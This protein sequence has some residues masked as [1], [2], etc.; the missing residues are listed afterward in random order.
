MARDLTPEDYAQSASQLQSVIDA[1]VTR[2]QSDTTDRNAARLAKNLEPVMS[3][4]ARCCNEVIV[5]PL[6]QADLGAILIAY[7]FKTI[8]E[9][10]KLALVPIQPTPAMQSAWSV[11]LFRSLQ[12]RY[13]EVLKASWSDESYPTSKKP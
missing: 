13:R 5:P 6:G 9:K 10:H 7:Q 3:E 8:L 4:L 2:H 1:A 11:G 12:N